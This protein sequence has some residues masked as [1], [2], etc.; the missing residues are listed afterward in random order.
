MAALVV[1]MPLLLLQPMP[2]ALSCDP[3]I[4]VIGDFSTPESFGTVVE[5]GLARGKRSNE[6]RIVPSIKK[7]EIYEP[8][9]SK[10]TASTAGEIRSRLVRA[11][12]QYNVVAVVS[13][14]TSQT[15]PSV[16][17]TVSLFRVPVLLAVATTDNLLEGYSGIAYR[18]PARDVEQ[19]K[20]MADWAN[21]QRGSG[22]VGVLYDPRRYGANLHGA[23]VNQM[24]L[25]QVLSFPL[26]P[27]S[28]VSV[29][30]DYGAKAGVERWIVV[31]YREQ[32]VEVLARK[33]HLKIPG[34]VLLSDGA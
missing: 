25:L 5:R 1:L 24:G 21:K 27:S 23:L 30:L 34:A 9:V 12:A 8:V 15:A 32:A 10:I 16:L 31:G 26:S 22:P 29:Q 2:Q 14:N 28:E 19:A 20:A 11:F 7:V 3:V 4:L 17:E 6:W 13:A 18:L 33:K